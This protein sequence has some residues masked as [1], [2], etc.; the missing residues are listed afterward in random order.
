MS[1][2][3]PYAA[4]GLLSNV[5]DLW[6]WEQTLGSGKVLAP[7]R[8]A[9]ARS[10]Q[11]L[12]DGRGTGCGFGCQVG[13]LDGHVTTEHGGR[14]H[15]FSGYTL[16]VADAGLFVAVL[17][18]TDDKS[19][20]SPERLAT[21]I[22]RSLLDDRTT[23]LGPAPERVLREYVGNYRGP[24]GELV[25]FSVSPAGLMVE[26]KGGRRPLVRTEDDTFLSR[27]D[28]T[29]FRFVRDD[30][31]QVQ[32]VL[33]HPRLGVELLLSRRPDGPKDGRDP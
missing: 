16:G 21:R 27:R 22:A 14:A 4:G 5:D 7:A 23:I 15:G 18:N 26:D 11:K 2:T 8:L 13:T 3:L 25:Q 6:K 29:R 20:L 19:A 30:Q 24:G 32:S 12:A 33:V 28:V 9:Q 17:C 1:T 31:K 10:E